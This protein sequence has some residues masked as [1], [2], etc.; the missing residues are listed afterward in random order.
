MIKV[1]MPMMNSAAKTPILTSAFGESQNN[2]RTKTPRLQKAPRRTPLCASRQTQRK[3][4]PAI[5][6]RMKNTNIST[7]F[8]DISDHSGGW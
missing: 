4:P 3:N 7:G 1:G 2:H 8:Q 5:K 6:G